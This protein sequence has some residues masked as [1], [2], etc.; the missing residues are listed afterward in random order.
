[1]TFVA[2][3]TSNRGRM[4]RVLVGIA[5]MSVG[6][7][8]RKS[9]AGAVLALIA[10]LPIAGGILDFC[11]AGVLLGYP[12]RGTEARERLAQERHSQ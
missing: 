9:T 2:F 10:L 3:M 7:F 1:M 6:L 5:L 11:L 8:S 4:M 12:F